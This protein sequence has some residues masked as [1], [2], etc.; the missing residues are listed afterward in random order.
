MLRSGFDDELREIRVGEK[1]ACFAGRH[2]SYRDAVR[3][4]DALADN[5]TLQGLA[6]H[7]SNLDEMAVQVLA[8]AISQC[9]SITHLS[10]E[11]AQ[12]TDAGATVLSHAIERLHALQSLRLSANRIADTGVL[13][14]ARAIEGKRDLLMVDLRSN[15]VGDAGAT[16]LVNVA[17]ASKSL[18]RIDLRDNALMT[19]YSVPSL[20]AAI[21]RSESL[22][23]LLVDP[24]N[25]TRTIND[26]LKEC[27]EH[28][29]LKAW[30]LGA[31][32]CEETKKKSASQKLAWAD[33][34]HAI[35]FRVGK[36]LF[37]K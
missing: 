34:D 25:G 6:F 13:A 36:F 5:T 1:T 17:A 35:L 26:A 4:A 12:I 16:A 22:R 8:P 31:N 14:I 2:I 20:V 30:V 32:F 37:S 21:L 19:R 10:F 18:V 3:V 33:G 15:R 7:A 29:P 23:E 11:V 9:R 28:R 24:W 27:I